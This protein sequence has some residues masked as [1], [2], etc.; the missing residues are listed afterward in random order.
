MLFRGA[1]GT[2]NACADVHARRRLV[3][4]ALRFSR[5]AAAVLT[6][7]L[8]DLPCG[9]RRGPPECSGRAARCLCQA[10]SGRHHGLGH[11][12]GSVLRPPVPYCLLQSGEGGRDRC[13]WAFRLRRSGGQHHAAV[14]KSLRSHACSS[15]GCRLASCLHP[16]WPQRLRA[17]GLAHS[18][19]R[20]RPPACKGRPFVHTQRG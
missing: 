9:E 20:P 4:T 16:F 2:K 6:S 15:P 10:R 1:C 19:T 5:R 3:V 13:W 8:R 18:Q 17:G 12:F 7:C 14:R 11:I